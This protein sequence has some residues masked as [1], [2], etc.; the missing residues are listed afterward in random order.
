MRRGAQRL[1]A[2]K[3]AAPGPR[4][5]PGRRR[6]VLNA[7]RH[8]RLLHY[9]DGDDFFGFKLCSTP[10]GIKDC[11]T[12]LMLVASPAAS[13]AQRLSASKIAALGVRQAHVVG[14][15]VCSTP[16][17]IKDCC[18]LVPEDSPE[19]RGAQRL[20]ASKI[21]AP[22]E[23]LETQQQNF[24]LNAFR[25]QR[26]LHRYRLQR[27]PRL[28][29]VLNAFRHQRLLHAI[30]PPIAK[31]GARCSTPFG[32]KDCCTAGGAVALDD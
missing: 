2:S 32:I 17:G 7:F 10:F 1:S 25:H 21:A 19:G 11:C 27:N 16:F 28:R 18:T 23:E 22:Q 29:E 6:G 30:W 8:Q 3:I 26:L 15:T 4:Y 9:G 31:T 20:S 13:S 12:F 5:R 14:R 24:V